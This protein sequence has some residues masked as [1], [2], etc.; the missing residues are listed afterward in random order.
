[1]ETFLE[2]LFWTSV[3]SIGALAIVIIKYVRFKKEKR[4]PIQY[5]KRED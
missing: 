5:S 2:V 1:M 4:E 3:I